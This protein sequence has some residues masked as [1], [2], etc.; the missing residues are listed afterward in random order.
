MSDGLRHEWSRG[1]DV[2]VFACLY[3]LV[4]LLLNYWNGFHVGIND[5][6]ANYYQ[7]DNQDFSDAA[8]LYDGF[9]PIGYPT[10][11]RMLPGDD[12]VEAGFLIAAACRML[13]IGGFGTIALRY[14]PGTWALA[15]TGAFA[16]L[17]RVFE[18][19]FSPAADLPM[20]VLGIAGAGL[21]LLAGNP[22]RP[23]QTRV[24]LWIGA[25]VLFGYSGL[26]R[27]HG[28]VLAA[29]F[30]LGAVLTRP[31]DFFYVLLCGVMC[32][33]AYF[34]QFIVNVRTGHGLF[35]TMQYVN[36]YKMMHG[37]E[38]RDVPLDLAPDLRKIISEDPVRFF[39]EWSRYVFG[40]APVLI[41][42]L[43]AS[44]AMRDPVLRRLGRI[45]LI[46]GVPYLAAVALGW[47]SRAVLPMIPWAVL[48]TACLVQR[49]QAYVSIRVGRGM[50][51]NAV[52]GA[53]V[54]VIAAL[55]SETNAGLVRGYLL[56][57]HRYSEV[58]KTVVGQGLVHPKQ[59]YATDGNL[60]LPL[61]PP[62]WPYFD[63]TWA[64]YSLYQYNERYPRLNVKSVA[65]FAHDCARQG[66]THIALAGNALEVGPA[67][68]ELLKNPGMYPE[69]EYVGEVGNYAL[70]RRRVIN[71]R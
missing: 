67:L 21:L 54:L 28:L 23:R 49:T 26:I 58:E 31:R 17:P 68:G 29:G 19:V 65:G 46:A 51:F 64:H 39:A 50:L 40:M 20:I 12:Y 33:A 62:H 53:S 38:L 60:Y 25:G 42:A 9:F 45:V 10:L 16:I 32:T 37:V 3:S 13:L 14:L 1:R 59:L 15:A 47:S 11:L 4:L 24:A 8:T 70:F 22:D 44:L 71:G 56:D 6:W 34:P 30:M 41:P 43:L 52:V 63:G 55:A 18:N 57:H 48:L 35:E 36:V 27:Q 5:F 66:I 2:W 69:F 7:A 61:T